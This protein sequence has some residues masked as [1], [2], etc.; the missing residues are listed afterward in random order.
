MSIGLS[1]ISAGLCRG[2]LPVCL[3]A[4]LPLTAALQPMLQQQSFKNC[5]KH[6][7]EAAL[8][9]QPVSAIQEQA[10]RVVAA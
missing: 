7:R 6:G 9:L 4:Q 3:L 2:F 8:S 10:I 1:E 5:V